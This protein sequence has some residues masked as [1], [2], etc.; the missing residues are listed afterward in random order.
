MA[1]KTKKVIPFDLERAFNPKNLIKLNSNK[2]LTKSLPENCSRHLYESITS[3]SYGGYIYGRN[4]TYLSPKGLISYYFECRGCKNRIVIKE[5]TDGKIKVIGYNP[6]THNP[7]NN[8]CHRCDNDNDTRA[9]M[10]HMKAFAQRLYLSSKGELPSE[11]LAAVLDEFGVYNRLHEFNPL[12]IIKNST[13]LN[14]CYQSYNKR[15]NEMLQ[16]L[17]PTELRF[18]NGASWLIRDIILPDAR[19]I[20]FASP[21]MINTGSDCTR[22]LLDGTYQSRP[23]E[24]QQI[25]NG[26]GYIPSFKRFMPLFHVLMSKLTASSYLEVLT[27]IFCD[28]FTFSSL[29]TINYD[30]EIALITALVSYFPKKDKYQNGRKYILQGCM[31]HFSQ[32]IKRHFKDLYKD[33]PKYEPY[34]QVFIKLP[35]LNTEDY[36][37]VIKYMNNDST[38][39]EFMKYFNQ[40]WGEGGRIKRLYWMARRETKLDERYTNDGVENYNG[41]ANKVMNHPNFISFIQSTYNLDK[42]IYLNAGNSKNASILDDK[43]ITHLTE[44]DAK[45]LISKKFPLIQFA[46]SIDKTEKNENCMKEPVEQ[47]DFYDNELK[48][49][50]RKHRHVSIIKNARNYDKANSGIKIKGKRRR[51]VEKIRNDIDISEPIAKKRSLEKRNKSENAKNRILRRRNNNIRYKDHESSDTSSDF[52]AK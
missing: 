38:I 44:K 11:I 31:F 12:P 22:L 9:G 24:F 51:S 19:F 26:V 37:S 42:K 35:L 7:H 28:I 25:L 2:E 23:P 14:W 30:Y 41:K 39:T 5:D 48:T 46:Q 21:E 6:D 27:T 1:N 47:D 4:T 50:N 20:F 34:F 52:D 29:K 15:P 45:N 8:S 33:D 3:I 16:Y 10:E 17:I 40:Q 49:K 43:C 18:I 32:A 36:N 13:I